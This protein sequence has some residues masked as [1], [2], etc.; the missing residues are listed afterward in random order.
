MSRGD[1]FR[2]HR[3]LERRQSERRAAA[4]RRFAAAGG[5]FIDTSSS[6]SGGESERIVGEFIRPDR[7]RW[8]MASKYAPS[9]TLTT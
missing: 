6:Y 2:R 9:T 3:K 5:N 1:D 4:V 7:D 8:V